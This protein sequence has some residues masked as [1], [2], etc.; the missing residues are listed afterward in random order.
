MQASF[1]IFSLSPPSAS[2][3]RT[4]RS[5]PVYLTL[6]RYTYLDL[7]FLVSPANLFQALHYDNQM[8][9]KRVRLFWIVFS[10]LFVWEIIPQCMLRIL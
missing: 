10:V 1:P 9:S 8:T 2:G 4:V 5:F 7:P 3:P 6:L